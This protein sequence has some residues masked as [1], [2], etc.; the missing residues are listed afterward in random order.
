MKANESSVNLIDRRLDTVPTAPVTYRPKYPLDT[1]PDASVHNLVRSAVV[2]QPSPFT[3]STTTTPA[4]ITTTTAVTYYLT[5]GFKSTSFS[6]LDDYP[7]RPAEYLKRKMYYIRN[8]DIAPTTY[9]PPK[10]FLKSLLK[11]DLNN[12]EPSQQEYVIKSNGIKTIRKY[13]N[14]IAINNVFASS[15]ELYPGSIEDQSSERERNIAW[16]GK[17]RFPSVSIGADE[18]TTYRYSIPIP[19]PTTT[20]PGTTTTTTT[21]TT[22]PL[23]PQR[24]NYQTTEQYRHYVEPSPKYQNTV[25]VPQFHQLFDDDEPLKPIPDQLPSYKPKPVVPKFIPTTAGVTDDDDYP[26]TTKTVPVSSLGSTPN[27]VTPSRVSR[28]NAAIKSMIGVSAARGRPISKC[29]EGNLKC[30]EL[31]QRYTTSSSSNF[32]SRVSSILF[33]FCFYFACVICTAC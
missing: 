11:S 13:I 32:Y 4:P 6:N 14:P 23:P 3:P 19:L 28:V 24:T 15:T 16:R 1:L 33:Y 29:T 22:T 7:S 26:S 18:V 25:E 17:V 10:F 20:T 12:T 2:N 5:K 27:P 9:A 31:K 8:I 30:S 21:T